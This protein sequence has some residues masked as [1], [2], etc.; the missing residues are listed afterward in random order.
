MLLYNDYDIIFSIDEYRREISFLYTQNYKLS[1]RLIFT[2]IRQTVGKST[3]QRCKRFKKVEGTKRVKA[4]T[5]GF[6]IIIQMFF[7]LFT[8][9]TYI[10]GRNI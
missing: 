6:I 9:S 7:D 3:L 10:R 4:N 1:V 2:I 8:L 5:F